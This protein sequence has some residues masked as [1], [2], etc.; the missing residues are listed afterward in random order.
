ML[1]F[2]RRWPEV[3]FPGR[4]KKYSQNPPRSLADQKKE[5]YSEKRRLP[6]KKKAAT[7]QRRLSKEA[8][9]KWKRGKREAEPGT[10]QPQSKEG[11]ER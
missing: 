7:Q 3:F 10:A 6:G 8:Q 1:F 11:V 2:G 4:S 9:A 5:I